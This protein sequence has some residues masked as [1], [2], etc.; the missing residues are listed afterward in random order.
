[1]DKK[2]TTAKRKESEARKRKREEPRPAIFALKKSLMSD[3]IEEWNI[4]GDFKEEEEIDEVE[5]FDVRRQ[6][7]ERS[8]SPMD[9]DDRRRGVIVITPVLNIMVH[10]DMSDPSQYQ[11]H[12]SALLPSL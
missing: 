8:P 6:H 10:R 1:V 3:A 5:I 9:M 4:E 2:A 7:D 12:A 11:S